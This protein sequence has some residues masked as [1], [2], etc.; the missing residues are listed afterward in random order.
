MTRGVL[1][2][3]TERIVDEYYDEYSEYCISESRVISR[4]EIFDIGNNNMNVSKY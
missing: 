2:A 4:V 1:L 3:F